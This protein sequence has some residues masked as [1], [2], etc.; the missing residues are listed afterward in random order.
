MTT[1]TASLQQVSEVD[2]TA[3]VNRRLQQPQVDAINAAAS[4]AAQQ[5]DDYLTHLI[6]TA[7]DTALANI[8]VQD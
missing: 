3:T 8:G 6:Q 5:P 2:L 1:V 7:V 4:N